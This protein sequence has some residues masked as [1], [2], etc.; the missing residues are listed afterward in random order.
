M[1]LNQMSGLPMDLAVYGSGTGPQPFATV[2]GLRPVPRAR[3]RSF[4]AGP[5]AP[6]RMMR[7]GM[8]RGITLPRPAMAKVVPQLR[9]IVTDDARRTTSSGR[10]SRRCRQESPAEDRQRISDGL[11]GRAHARSAARVH[12]ARGFHRARLSTGGAHH[13]GL[14]RIC[15]T[16]RAWYRWRIRGATTMDMPPTRFTSS[17]SRKSRAFAARCSP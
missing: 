3:A 13:G 4:R 17:A 16:A 10:P 9:E 7:A 5:T 11:R 6:S 1:P 14:E 15:P 12:A 8:A 2:Q